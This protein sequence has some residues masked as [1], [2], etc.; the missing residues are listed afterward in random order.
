MPAL[1]LTNRCRCRAA[2]APVPLPVHPPSL[3][4]RELHD[5]YVR[6]GEKLEGLIKEGKLLKSSAS[7][8]AGASRTAVQVRAATCHLARPGVLLQFNSS[9]IGQS[10][11]SQ[12]I[13]CR[14]LLATAAPHLACACRRRSRMLRQR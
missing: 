10:G 6:L 3:S 14:V 2:A 8:E 4:S 5:K 7:A 13:P 12:A 11:I 9:A 1:L